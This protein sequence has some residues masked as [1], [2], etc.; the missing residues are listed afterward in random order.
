[1]GGRVEGKRTLIVG[2]GGGIGGA[3][4]RRFHAEGASVAIVDVD[5]EA[6][7]RMAEVLREGPGNGKVLTLATDIGEPGAA[8]EAVDQ[9][10]A[11]LGG[12]D[13]TVHS[14][15]ARESTATVEELAV[16]EWHE[17]VRVN[18]T[19]MFYLCKYALPH[20][21]ADGGGVIVNI[22]SQF[23]SVATAGRPAYHATKG[24]VI[25][26]TRALAVENA[27]NG[28]RAVSI[29]PGAIETNRLLA[30]HKTFERVRERLVPGHPI[31]RLGLPEEIANAVL[32]AASDEAAF[33]TGSDL[34]VDGG[35][36][37]V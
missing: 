7:A 2:G 1:M 4:A 32:F 26:L 31:G 36:T 35:Y 23:G 6:G 18:L 37:A 17:V 14:A 25:Q 34:L 20:L 12:L 9:A 16:E 13:V 19:S 5:A 8:R 3:T 30:R 21:R 11:E 33:M 27:A 22:A 24:A 10:A 15:A 29:S 28:I